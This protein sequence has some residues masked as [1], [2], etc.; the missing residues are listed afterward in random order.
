[1][2]PYIKTHPHIQGGQACIAGTRMPAA[3]VAR[4]H[5]DGWNVQTFYPWLTKDQIRTCVN[6]YRQQRGKPEEYD[7]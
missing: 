7:E 4:M 3:D 5:L 1:M 2:R 6:W